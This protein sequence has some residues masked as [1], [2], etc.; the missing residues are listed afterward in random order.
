MLK[1]KSRTPYSYYSTGSSPQSTPT[2]DT[3][4]YTKTLPCL[5]NLSRVFLIVYRPL[6]A[7]LISFLTVC[8]LPVSIILAKR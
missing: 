3:A 1:S 2:A 5:C 7:G 6:K 4:P 8:R